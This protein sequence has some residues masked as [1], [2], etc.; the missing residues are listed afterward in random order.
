MREGAVA[1]S[2]THTHMYTCGT[3]EA[4]VGAAATGAA[5][6]T[7]D[8]QNLFRFQ[9][10]NK[11]VSPPRQTKK[12]ALPPNIRIWFYCTATAFLAAAADPHCVDRLLFSC[13]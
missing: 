10:P 11:Q 8:S 12:P 1:W 4:M 3:H 9:R 13:F 2:S 5:I 7:P 6:L